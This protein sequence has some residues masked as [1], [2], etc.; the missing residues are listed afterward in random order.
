MALYA[1]DGTWNSDEDDPKT[2]PMLYDLPSYTKV[3]MPSMWQVS[4]LALEKS[5]GP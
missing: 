1:F 2:K 5:A 4:V 3:K